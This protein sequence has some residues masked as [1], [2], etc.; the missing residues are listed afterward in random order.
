[1][2]DLHEIWYDDA[3]WP[4]EEYGQLKFLTLKIQHG[5]QPPFF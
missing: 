2:T 3:H 1:M 5:G 4:S